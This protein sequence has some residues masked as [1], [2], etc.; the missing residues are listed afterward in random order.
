LGA[1]TPASGVGW[2]DNGGWGEKPRKMRRMRMGRL[3]R[4]KM[5]KKKMTKTPP[6][7]KKKTS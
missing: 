5:T 3:G 1:F 7:T 6:P 2:T 4:K